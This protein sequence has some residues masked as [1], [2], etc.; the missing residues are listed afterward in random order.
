MVSFSAIPQDA[1]DIIRSFLT[2]KEVCKCRRVS[3]RWNK[4]DLVWCKLKMKFGV[5]IPEVINKNQFGGME[6][7]TL[8]EL[9]KMHQ[10]WLRKLR[11]FN[12]VTPLKLVTKNLPRFTN[13]RA[14]QLNV[15]SESIFR[16]LAY[17]APKLEI[18]RADALS[19]SLTLDF[20]DDRYPSLS[21]IIFNYA[22]P[23]SF[24][25]T[26]VMVKDY[27]NRFLSRVSFGYNI[28]IHLGLLE[29]F[30]NTGNLTV[31]IHHENEEFFTIINAICT[32]IRYPIYPKQRFT[33]GLDGPCSVDFTLLSRNIMLS[34]QAHFI[35]RNEHVKHLLITITSLL[36][37]FKIE[38]NQNDKAPKDFWISYLRDLGLLDRFIESNVDLLTN[39]FRFMSF[40][41][42]LET[43]RTELEEIF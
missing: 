14:I 15:I 7:E 10:K 39:T 28:R 40:G 33:I 12:T 4:L 22:I 1:F 24:T 43:N 13:L 23:R 38:I 41:N 31:K 35:N 8:R 16:G 34:H 36:P 2:L 6:N 20:S 9:L 11:L 17:N 37:N 3:R 25:T 27:D 26:T 5:C 21:Q 29:L 30:R 19:N 42:P 18:I 32:S